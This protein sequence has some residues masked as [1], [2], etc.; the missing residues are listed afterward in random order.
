METFKTQFPS[1][2]HFDLHEPR[3]WNAVLSEGFA[4]QQAYETRHKGW[5]GSLFRGSR[6][7]AD[8]SSTITTVL[9]RTLPS[10]EYSSIVCGASVPTPVQY[11]RGRE[12]ITSLQCHPRLQSL[13]CCRDCTCDGI[14]D[15]ERLSCCTRDGRTSPRPVPS[16]LDAHGCSVRGPS[17]TSCGHHGHHGVVAKAS[18]WV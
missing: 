17:R 2:Q 11:T 12:L 16:A 15:T 18:S 7:V 8:N 6:K 13:P 9:E 4:V 1:A 10:G 14:E 5:K 3:T